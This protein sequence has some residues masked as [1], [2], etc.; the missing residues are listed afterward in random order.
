[1]KQYTRDYKSKGYT[2]TTLA[3]RWCVVPKTISEIS[4]NPKP[5]HLDALVGLPEFIDTGGK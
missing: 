5:I 1:M 2:R 4:A 3:K